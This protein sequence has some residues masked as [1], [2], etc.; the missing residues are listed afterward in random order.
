MTP[1]QALEEAHVLIQKRGWVQG[2]YKSRAGA[3]CLVGALETV[4]GRFTLDFEHKTFTTA[5]TRLLEVV[6]DFDLVG[7][8]DAPGRTKK[9]VL[10]ALKK[11]KAP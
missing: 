4:C 7:W 2:E 5:S 6:G 9:Q 3:Y 1:N 10:K 8:N 11:A